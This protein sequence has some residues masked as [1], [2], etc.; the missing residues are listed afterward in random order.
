MGLLARR[1]LFE[2]AP[3]LLV[4]L[5]GI[6]FAVCLVTIQVG[7]YYGFNRSTT[8]LMDHSKAD[9][10]V[11][12][13]EMAF[14]ELSAPIK[15][16][17]LAKARAIPGVAR[18]EALI[19][20]TAPWVGPNKKL[21]FVKVIGFDPEGELFRPL[22]VRSER[23][24]AMLYPLGIIIDRTNFRSL[25]VT[26][27]G[28]EGHIGPLPARILDASNGNQSIV[29]P[30][31]IFTSLRN[32]DLYLNGSG[33]P[34]STQLSVAL[35]RSLR[36][37]ASINFILVKVKRGANV[38]DVRRRLEQAL[39]GTRVYTTREIADQTTAYWR[40]R[41]GVGF[42]VTLIA[43][44]GVIVGIVVVGQI[45]YVSV[46]EHVKEY[47]TLKA[48][49]ASDGFLYG[50]I[51]RQG[52]LMA[53]LGYF[54]SLLVCWLLGMWT[55]QARGVTI[56]ITPASAALVFVL[57]IVMCVVAGSFAMHKVTRLDPVQVFKA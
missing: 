28:E 54:P 51:V 16:N 1:N 55:Y 2:D 56:L 15:Y 20:R 10:W 17:L 50:I 6:V 14:F 35:M 4:A 25:Y 24:D 43:F 22:G 13:S 53:I 34:T 42:I 49:G 23:L 31:Y 29:S 48:M 3:R 36:D 45:L 46:S 41:T 21:E 47:G 44:V 37:D 32:A 40:K 39:P 57:T 8:S 52:L 30:A 9:L 12:S 27:V 38:F 7:I 33:L 11:A 18:A 26:R 5:S 19:V